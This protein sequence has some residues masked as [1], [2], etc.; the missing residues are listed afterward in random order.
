EEKIIFGDALAELNDFRIH[1]VEANALV[2]VLAE[3]QRLAVDQLERGVGLGVALRGIFPGAVVEDVAVLVDLEKGGAGVLGGALE[4][5]AEV[6]DVD[7]D[8]TGDEGGFTANGERQRMERVVNGARRRAGCLFAER[9][10]RRVLAL[11]ETVDTV[12]E[13]HDVDVEIAADGVHQM[14]S[15][16]REAVAIARDDPD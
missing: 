10:S 11:G 12:V 13:Q 4:R 5:F 16:D 7:I 15:A 1:A 6:L 8:A 2:T 14:V 9:R 3:D